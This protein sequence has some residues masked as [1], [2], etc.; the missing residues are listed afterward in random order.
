[1]AAGFLRAVVFFRAVV[2]LAAGFLRAVV[3]FRA[4]VFLAAGFLRAVVF[5]R[6]VAF[7]RVALLALLLLAGIAIT[8]LIVGFRLI[9]T[10]EVRSPEMGGEAQL[11]TAACQGGRVLVTLEPLG[12]Q[13]GGSSRSCPR[14]RRRG[15]P[16]FLAF[17]VWGP[18]ARVGANFGHKGRPGS[19][20]KGD[21][22]GARH[23]PDVR[24][25]W[26]SAGRRYGQTD[27]SRPAGGDTPPL[28]DPHGRTARDALGFRRARDVRRLL[29]SVL[30]RGGGGRPQARL[31][32]AGVRLAPPAA[33]PHGRSS[34]WT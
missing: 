14:P 29:L 9:H 5:F 32:E 15:P 31:P 25:L 34:R 4:A 33:E 24:R 23:V 7:L 12:E 16:G 27:P 10:I 2:F 11:R 18:A 6:V 17:F 1:L 30:L 13:T 28:R 19:G 3:F 21:R 26:R 20:T 8:F 22:E